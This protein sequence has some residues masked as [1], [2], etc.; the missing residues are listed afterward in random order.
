MGIALDNDT[1][2]PYP[3]VVFTRLKSII[4]KVGDFRAV[5]KALEVLYVPTTVSEFHQRAL[6]SFDTA[7]PDCSI[8]YGELNFKTGR[9]ETVRNYETPYPNGEFD[10]I[11]NE[12]IRDNP[13]VAYVE[14][15]GTERVIKISDLMT[16]REF[17]KTDLYN[18]LM[19]PC[20]LTHH[21]SAVVPKPGAVAGVGV[22]WDRDFTETHRTMLQFMAP[23]LAQAS[24]NAEVFSTLLEVDSTANFSKL[25]SA[26]LSQR[27][28]EVLFWIREGKRDKEIAMML[29][30]ST[31]TVHHHVAGILRKLR[32]KSRTA[33]A[34]IAAD[35]L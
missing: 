14:K 31:R 6:E 35:L 23:H 1:K 10:R 21:I 27:Q 30:V 19:R 28:C 15:G 16:Q 13:V 20:G 26:G 3:G 8:S 25:L 4:P 7:F 32:V 18:L 22:N 5:C 2:N 9:L 11:Q 12:V 17:R 34:S 24:R 33:A 29:S